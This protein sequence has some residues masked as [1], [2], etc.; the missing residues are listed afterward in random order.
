M[1]SQPKPPAPRGAGK[2]RTDPI[3]DQ[4]D[5]LRSRID[6]VYARQQAAEEKADQSAG[7]AQSAA[8][9]S[10]GTLIIL[11]ISAVGGCLQ[12]SSLGR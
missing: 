1:A 4:L 11:L 7:W 10:L 12:L 5:D 6:A 9:W 2:E 8:W 3:N